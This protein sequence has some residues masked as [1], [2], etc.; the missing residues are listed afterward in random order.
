MTITHPTSSHHLLH[1]LK[2]TTQ[3]LSDARTTI[4][5]LRETQETMAR[6]IL[7]LTSERD[8]ARNRADRLHA[9]LTDVQRDLQ[10][11]LGSHY[12]SAPSAAAAVI[13]RLNHAEHN[14]RHLH[15]AVHHLTRELRQL[16]D[17]T[18]SPTAEKITTL[19]RNIDNILTELGSPP[20]TN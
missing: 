20:P 18:D 10:T 2:T 14:Y 9:E 6:A 8:E 19:T 11:A 7:V 5:K 16:A 13:H 12:P 15:L 4:T 1:T 3:E 17:T